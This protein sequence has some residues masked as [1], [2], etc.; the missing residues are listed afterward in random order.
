M[1]HCE[2]SNLLAQPVDVSLAGSEKCGV[3]AAPH[4]AGF[5]LQPIGVTAE[6]PFG[7]DVGTGTQ[8]NV[9]AL[10]SANLDKFGQVGLPLEIKYAR[11]S[12][13]NVPKDIGRDCVDTHGLGSAD[14]VAPIFLRYTG[15]VH[16]AAN[17]LLRFA[18]E[19]EFPILNFEFLCCCE[20]T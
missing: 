1:G 5:V 6:I 3:V 18:V 19:Q 4:H 7:T 16:F 15:V 20:A 9:H 10:L 11:L 14:A 2:R 17:E 13:V 12:L 8:D